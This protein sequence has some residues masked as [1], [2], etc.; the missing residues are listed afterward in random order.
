MNP[1]F[2]GQT[3]VYDSGQYHTEPSCKKSKKSLEPFLR[4]TGNQLLTVTSWNDLLNVSHIIYVLEWIGPFPKY[5]KF[6]KCQQ[7]TRILLASKKKGLK[8]GKLRYM[9]PVIV[10][11][12]TENMQHTKAP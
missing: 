1:N 12:E 4:K 3:A 11:K 8:K 6:W 7:A 5:R 10:S 2:F 9:K